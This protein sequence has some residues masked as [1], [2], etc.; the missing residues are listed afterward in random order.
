MS[1]EESA[2]YTLPEVVSEQQD[3]EGLYLSDEGKRGEL[4]TTRFET[5]RGD[6]RVFE[7]EI[8][9]ADYA[10]TTRCT[11]LEAEDGGL[12]MVVSGGGTVS[13]FEDGDNISNS[14]VNDAE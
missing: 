5:E 6:G 4:V 1:S 8:T 14:Q 2:P 12:K 9:Y 11:I 13:I 7:G 3:R 10:T